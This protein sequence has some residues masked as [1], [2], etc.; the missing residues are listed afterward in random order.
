MSIHTLCDICRHTCDDEKPVS[1]KL[2]ITNRYQDSITPPR[3]FSLHICKNCDLKL[4]NAI[5]PYL[6]S[7]AYHI[8]PNAGILEGEKH[9]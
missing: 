9:E 8:E 1:L 2:E 3:T 5:L 6:P 7:V 4:A